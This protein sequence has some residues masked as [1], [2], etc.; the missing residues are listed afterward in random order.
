MAEWSKAEHLSCSLFGGAGS[1]PAGVTIFKDSVA[2]WSKAEHLSC[3][4]FGGAG[5]NP[6]AVIILI[7]ILIQ[8]G[9]IYYLK[10]HSQKKN[11]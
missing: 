6:A 11:F 7:I 5:S 3:S 2:E 1:N 10:T 9:M 8:F 4:L